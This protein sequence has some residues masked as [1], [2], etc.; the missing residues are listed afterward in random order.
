MTPDFLQKKNTKARVKS[1]SLNFIQ[2]Q[3]CPTVTSL[4]PDK[5]HTTE[6]TKASFKV[7]A[8]S[9]VSPK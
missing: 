5:Y 9:R 1:P 6:Q 3:Q 8:R 4:V 2:I 7:T